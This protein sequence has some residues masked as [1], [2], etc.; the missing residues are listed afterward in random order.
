MQK[1]FEFYKRFNTL[2]S[3]LRKGWIMRNVPDPRGEDD[4]HHT[5]QTMLLADLII[6]EKEI[7]DVNLLR[8]LDM[9][10]IHEIGETIID[11]ISM[12][13]ADYKKKKQAEAAAVKE[14]LSCLGEE[15][16]DYYFAIWKEFEAH[17]TIDGQFAYFI[18][19]LDAVFKAQKYDEECKT[20][21][22]YFDSFYP[23]ALG[24]LENNEFVSL[25]RELK[26]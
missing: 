16:G 3:V 18:D 17:E 11:D 20:G 15:L 8:V 5:L 26:L 7:K 4:M 10:L 19:K 12:I 21:G 23:H 22:T 24:I 2:A 25:M 6:R 14:R 9:L 1:I 13:E